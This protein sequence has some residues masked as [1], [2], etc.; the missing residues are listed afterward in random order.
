[1]AAMHY[2][3]VCGLESHL[4]VIL[5]CD[6]QNCRPVTCQKCTHARNKFR[7]G[8]DGNSWKYLKWKQ[9]VGFLLMSL[10]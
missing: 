9:V 6:R 5:P 4:F 10:L 3:N 1:M 8:R 7:I 2:H